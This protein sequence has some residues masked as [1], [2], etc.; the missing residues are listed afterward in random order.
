MREY[1]ITY[2]KEAPDWE[3]IPKLDIDTVLWTEPAPIDAWAQICRD[4]RALH[5]RLS[6]IE[7]Y[8]RAEN[9]DPMQEPCEDSCLEFFFCP[10][11][12]DNRY[13]NIEFNPNGLMYLG[14]GSGAHDLI[15]L[16]PE[17]EPITPHV[18]RTANGWN[19]TY[20]VPYSLILR[21]F[22]NFQPVSGGCIRANCFKCGNLTVHPHYL[23]WNP[24][25]SEKPA[26]H[27]PEDF[28]VMYFA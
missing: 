7:P 17:D 12:E 13:F 14:F 4:D 26:F 18:V 2:T 10:D 21:F 24:V 19:L 25:T 9:R 11:P 1:T 16:M 22:P 5:V 20:S 15:R 28:G 3:N 23:S 6:A 8:I 27:R